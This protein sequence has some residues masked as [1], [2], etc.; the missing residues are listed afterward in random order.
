MITNTGKGILAK[1]LIG[2]IS[3]YASYI[4][5][6]VGPEPFSEGDSLPSFENK[7]NLEFEVFRVPIVSRGYVYDE[8][9]IANVVF[10][11]ELPTDQRYEITEI[12]IY[13]GSSNPAAGVLDSKML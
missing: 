4:A 13:P 9:G 2:Q 7:K 6:G 10:A 12:G 8:N 5:V 3:S 1:Y 11:A